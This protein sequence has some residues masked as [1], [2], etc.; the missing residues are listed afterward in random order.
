VQI[1]GGKELKLYRR[2]FST[3]RIGV[4]KDGF[5]RFRAR[6]RDGDASAHQTTVPPRPT[7][8]QDPALNP[9]GRT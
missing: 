3:P 8:P 1:S 9:R 5:M 2:D 6:R 4:D 7:G